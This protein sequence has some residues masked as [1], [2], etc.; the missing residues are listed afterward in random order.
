MIVSCC[1]IL[2]TIPIAIEPNETAKLIHAI[3]ESSPHCPAVGS[4]PVYLCVARHYVMS[5]A[6]PTLKKQ[7]LPSS[8]E[9]LQV[10]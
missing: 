8:R 6:F 9:A 7:H 10:A 3:V 1:I 5:N 4:T 2:L